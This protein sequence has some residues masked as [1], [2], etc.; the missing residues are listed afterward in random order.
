V[1]LSTYS[2]SFFIRC[3][4]DT[5]EETSWEAFYADGLETK[6]FG[7][8]AIYY[9]SVPSTMDVARKEARKGT[10]DGTV[11]IAGEQTEGR[12][13]M[14]RTW[15]SP[16]GNLAFSIILY[17]EVS[18]LPFLVIIAA[19]AVVYSIERA[20]GLRTLIKWPNDI[21]IGG[22]KVGGILIENEVKRNKVQYAIV[23]IGINM[24]VNPE[25]EG[26]TTV[27]STSLKDE[28]GG[29]LL[30]MKVL[31]NILREMEKLYLT[32]PDSRS[33]LREWRNRLVTLG[34]NVCV[35]S[36]GMKL[37]GVAEAVDAT[38]ALLLR[39][40]DGSLISIVAGD[41]TLRDNRRH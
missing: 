3:E 31:K 38:G 29:S 2:Y 7:Q 8:N 22:K 24:D 40:A 34:R 41:V 30:R 14:N 27:L 20:T 25:V 36:D 26:N 21:L 32:L 19:L 39:C 18:Y 23:G 37:E 1:V 5:V 12:G 11:V 35:Y 16:K 28:I 13:R 4:F 6:F 9:P 10:D 33:M 17:P 15:L